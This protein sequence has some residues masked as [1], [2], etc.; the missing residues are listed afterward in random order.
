LA[1]DFKT[2]AVFG[3]DDGNA[4]VAVALCE[5]LA[6]IL[7]VGAGYHLILQRDENSRFQ[8]RAGPR[9]HHV[10]SEWRF[11]PVPFVLSF[12]PLP[13]FSL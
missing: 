2:I 10:N 8:R 6:A 4:T 11:V 3:K 5:S 12:E 13:A 9:Q 7:A 1:P